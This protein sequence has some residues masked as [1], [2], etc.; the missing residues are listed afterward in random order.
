M[1]EHQ[2]QNDISNPIIIPWE[3]I[4]NNK[5]ITWLRY[6]KKVTF[7]IPNYSGP[8]HFYNVGILQGDSTS[9]VSI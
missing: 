7:H 2:V 6:D 4:H 8:I 5:Q 3:E 9:L 1:E